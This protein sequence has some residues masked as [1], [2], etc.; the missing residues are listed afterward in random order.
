MSILLF[1]YFLQFPSEQNVEINLNPPSL[2]GTIWNNEL[3]DTNKK[4]PA[5]QSLVSH[6]TLVSAVIR[7]LFIAAAFKRNPKS[8]SSSAPV[9]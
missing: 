5:E 1:L 4:S 8:R 7:T 2:K 9:I 6:N 3:K